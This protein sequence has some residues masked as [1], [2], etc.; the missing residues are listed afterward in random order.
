[1]IPSEV[2]FIHERAKAF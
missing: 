2:K 1:M